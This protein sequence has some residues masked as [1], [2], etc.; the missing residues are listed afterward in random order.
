MKGSKPFSS[1]RSANFLNF[2]LKTQNHLE[3]LLILKNILK[4]QKTKGSKIL[5]FFKNSILKIFLKIKIKNKSK[6][7]KT[8][9]YRLLTF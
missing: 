2:F 7:Y 5:N 4:N 1:M 8:Q 9:N 6:P 3:V